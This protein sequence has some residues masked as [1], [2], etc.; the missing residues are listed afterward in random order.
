MALSVNYEIVYKLDGVESWIYFHS[1]PGK[2]KAQGEKKFKQVMRDSGWTKRAKLIRIRSL[3]KAKDPPLTKAQQNALRSRSGSTKTNNPRR[4]RRA[5]G[6]K[7]KPKKVSG[8]SP[9]TSLSRLLEAGPPRSKV[10]KTK[11]PKN[12]RDSGKG[13]SRTTKSA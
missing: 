2:A 8:T 11:L 1:E 7:T 3:V 12:K 6:S 5:G 10:S 13:R 4:T 9:S